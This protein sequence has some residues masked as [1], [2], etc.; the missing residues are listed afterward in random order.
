VSRDPLA[1]AYRGAAQS[2]ADDASL[3]YV[4]LARHLLAHLDGRLPGSRALDAG[5]G[6]GAVGDLLRELG[7]TVVSVDLEPD[8]LRH[9]LDQRGVAVVGDLSRLPLREAQF[10]VA[11]AA[12]V[13]N[14]VTDHVACLREMARTTRPGGVV[15]ASVFGNDRS[16]VKEAVDGCLLEFGWAQPPWY[17]AVR[18]RAEATGTV[19]LLTGHARA[20]GLDRVEVH[21]VAVDVGLGV[22]EVVR[23]RLAMAHTRDFVLG[24]PEADRA[25][26]RRAAEAAVSDLGGD[27]RPEVLELVA[28]VD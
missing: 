4:P 14:H 25:D 2:W 20:A 3:V 24:L 10:D 13:L 22:P 12:F 28:W 1:G 9:H 18:D 11:V 17:A 23:Y 26:L 7:A 21:Q 15:L 8:M 6:T 5:A 27:F 16:P 19:E